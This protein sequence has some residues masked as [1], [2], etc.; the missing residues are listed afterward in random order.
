MAFKSF[1]KDLQS[2]VATCEEL[3]NPFMEESGD[4]LAVDTKDIM[5]SDV[6][7]TVNWSACTAYFIECRLRK[8]TTAISQK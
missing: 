3:G 4:L 7:E 5:N 8:Q 2:V 1:T 6:V